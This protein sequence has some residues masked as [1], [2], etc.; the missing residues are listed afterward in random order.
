[1]EDD[2]KIEP[3]VGMGCTWSVGS[4]RFAGTIVRL[5]GKGTVLVQEDRAVNGATW[6]D[7]RWCFSPDP[8]GCVLTFVLRKNGRYVLKGEGMRSRR[9]LRVGYRSKYVDPHF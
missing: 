8:D 2:S 7:Q 1:M 6:P 3:Q 4:D 5:V 9:D